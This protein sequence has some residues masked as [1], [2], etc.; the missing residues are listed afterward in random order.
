MAGG[1][2][3]DTAIPDRAEMVHRNNLVVEIDA[4]AARRHVELIAGSAE[5]PCTFQ[6]FDDLPTKDY[7][8]A[9]VFNGT[10]AECWDRLA[11]ASKNGCGVFITVNETDGRGR[12]AENIIRERLGQRPGKLL[13]AI[14]LAHT[15][16]C[17][18]RRLAGR[19]YDDDFAEVYAA[20]EYLGEVRRLAVTA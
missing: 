11:T 6:V 15:A 2:T 10:L 19:E 9:R 7:S 18:I 14:I 5:T 3:T 4:E 12:K 13:E 17:R 16:I 8:K 20:G 1:V